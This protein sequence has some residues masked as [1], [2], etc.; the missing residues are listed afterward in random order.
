M[1]IT[2][3]SGQVIGSLIG[4]LLFTGL[5]VTVFTSILKGVQSQQ[6]ILFNQADTLMLKQEIMNLVTSQENCGLY[7][8]DNAGLCA[9]FNPTL[10]QSTAAEQATYDA[11]NSLWQIKLGTQTIA[12]PTDGH[13]RFSIS[14]VSLEEDT[15]DTSVSRQDTVVGTTPAK[16]YLAWLRVT[17]ESRTLAS[18][19][20]QSKVISMPLS[21]E[22]D[23]STGSTKNRI[24]R[25]A[26]AESGSSDP[27]PDPPPSAGPF[28]RAIRYGAATS[29]NDTGTNTTNRPLYILEGSASAFVGVNNA[30]SSVAVTKVDGTSTTLTLAASTYDGVKCADG[31]KLVACSFA[32]TASTATNQNIYPIPNGCVTQLFDVGSAGPNYLTI[33]CSQ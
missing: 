27:D 24:I 17:V 21:I 22:A 18:S 7:L 14:N 16:K 12:S 13:G 2:H 30:S 9:K 11:N 10:P 28:A 1:R 25:C 31:W 6:N 20:S 29:T 26:S 19:D 4:A 23:A 3:R 33:T 15:T 8:L 32:M 5:A